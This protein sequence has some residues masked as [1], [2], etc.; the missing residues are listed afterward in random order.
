MNKDIGIIHGDLHMNNATVYQLYNYFKTG[1][2][3]FAIPDPHIAYIVDTNTYIFPHRGCFANIIDFSR[4]IIGD[5]SRLKH[6]FSARFADLYFIDQQN[7]VMQLL[8]HYFPQLIDKYRVEIAGLIERQFPNMFKI[9]TAIDTYSIMTNIQA[10]LTIDKVTDVAAKN[11]ELLTTL[12]KLSGDLIVNGIKS[13]LEHDNRD[14][15]DMEWPNL[16]II[17][18]AFGNFC[19][20]VPENTTLVEIFNSNNKI[21]YDINDFNSWGPLLS[22]DK[23]IELRQK[24]GLDLDPHTAGWVEY[25]EFDESLAIEKILSKY[26]ADEHDVLQ[27]DEWMFI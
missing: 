23:E 15:S 10:M 4:A 16:T 21:I 22:I 7:R 27:F 6:E 17:R 9:I 24:H 19:D 12:I 5:K 25:K 20:V 1:T 18:A 13:L 26:K 8:H 11:T 14:A 2:R 3:E